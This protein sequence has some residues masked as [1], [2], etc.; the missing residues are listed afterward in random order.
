MDAA[1]ALITTLLSEVIRAVEGASD[2]QL[3][4]LLSGEDHAVVSFHPY[5]PVS[6]SQPKKSNTP[7]DDQMRDVQELLMRTGS[8]EDGHAVL[9]ERFPQKDTLFVFSK[10]LDLPVQRKDS[11]ERIR[12]KIITHTVGRR[13]GG[14]A[15]RGGHVKG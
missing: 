5:R 7:S 15:I 6:E 3:S 10:F 14:E 13:L 8:R 12:D 11:V 1:R 9:T 4:R 2:E